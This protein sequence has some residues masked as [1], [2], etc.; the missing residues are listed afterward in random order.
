M[1]FPEGFNQLELLETHGHV[2]PV[3]TDSAWDE[4]GDNDHDEDDDDDDDEG[5]HSEE[6]YQEQELRRRD[7][8]AELMLWAAEKNRLCTVER[9]TA[10]DPSLV[11]CR[12]DDGYTPLHRASY[13]GHALVVSF[14][15]DSGADFRARTVDGWTPLHSASRWGHTH[16]AS[17]LLRRGSEVNATTNGQLTALQLAAG[18]PGAP[19]MLEL[20]LSQRTLQAGLRNSGGE[21]AYDIALRK[22]AHHGLFEI[23]EPCNN[24]Y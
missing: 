24:V 7:S 22:S 18:N 10:S 3:G 8:P 19:H 11:N 20:L 15:L 2:I 16:I 21:T 17:C 5:Q 9:L 4:D 13:S 6:W 14:L 23:T 12:D 1:E